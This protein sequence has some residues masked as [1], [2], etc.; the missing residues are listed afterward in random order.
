MAYNGKIRKE[1]KEQSDCCGGD[2]S[3]A[4][5]WWRKSCVELSLLEAQQSDCWMVGK[6]AAC[7]R[8]G[9][10]T[11]DWRV[12]AISGEGNEGLLLS[13]CSWWLKPWLLWWG[14][15]VGFIGRRGR[16][17]KERRR[18]WSGF[19]QTRIRTLRVQNFRPRP[20]PYESDGSKVLNGSLMGL[21]QSLFDLSKLNLLRVFLYFCKQLII[22]LQT[23][24]R[25]H[26]IQIQNNY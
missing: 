12:L 23:L 22:V 4:R 25:V 16:K 1:V 26:K 18:V 21:I 13:G 7:C 24:V 15:G 10:N 11:T 17:R 2:T 5:W 20:R 3:G 6:V 9:V 8:E 14:G 19:G